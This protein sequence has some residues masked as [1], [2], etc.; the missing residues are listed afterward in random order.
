MHPG[1]CVRCTQ[2][3]TRPKRPRA[4]HGTLTRASIVDAAWEVLRRDGVQGLSIRNVAA[5]LGVGAMS[6][7]RHFETKEDLVG[8]IADRAAEIVMQPGPT[9]DWRTSLRQQFVALYD[10]L[11]QYPELVALRR[12]RPALSPGA[13][14]FTEA[15]L[16][17]LREAGLS[18]AEAVRAYRLLYVH[19]FGFA[20]FGPGTT[21]ADE[22]EATRRA[23]SSLPPSDYPNLLALAGEAAAAM[24]DQTLFETGL[25]LLLDAVA[26]RR[27]G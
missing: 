23:L 17:A 24:G 21:A 4:A 2:V 8:A 5:E 3:A 11:R 22:G 12:L 20:A 1:T 9:G 7:Y 10:T 14:R 15:A 19:V 6:L 18:E 25:D 26:A 16:A 27:L 13:L